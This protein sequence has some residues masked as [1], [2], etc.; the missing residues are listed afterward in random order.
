[1]EQHGLKRKRAVPDIFPCERQV[2]IVKGPRRW[3]LQRAL[4][5]HGPD[6]DVR[7]SLD[8]AILIF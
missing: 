5:L 6:D 2:G 8:K 4:D 7:N 1:M 3:A